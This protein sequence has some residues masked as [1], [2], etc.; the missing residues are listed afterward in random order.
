MG[1][2]RDPCCCSLHTAAITRFV[3]VSRLCQ[4]VARRDFT[5]MSSEMLRCCDAVAVTLRCYRDNKNLV[6]FPKR[7]AHRKSPVKS[8]PAIDPN[9]HKPRR[10]NGRVDPAEDGACDV[11]QQNNPRVSR[12]AVP[13]WAWYSTAAPR[14]RKQRPGLSMG[15][16][17][18]PKATAINNLAC[19]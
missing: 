2:T 19:Q 16:S 4:D 12:D 6:S 10:K 3:A 13:F 15:L 9:C 8:T 14:S 11:H 5:S 18:E 1:R 17:D 7:D